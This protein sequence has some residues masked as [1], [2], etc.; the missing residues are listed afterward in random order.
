[1]I[2]Y[3]FEMNRKF[4]VASLKLDYLWHRIGCEKATNFKL[5]TQWEKLVHRN[6][7]NKL[8]MDIIMKLRIGISLN[9]WKVTDIEHQFLFNFIKN[10]IGHLS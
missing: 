1:M 9:I 4:A 8:I 7:H 3:L 2:F 5:A 10:K 6:S